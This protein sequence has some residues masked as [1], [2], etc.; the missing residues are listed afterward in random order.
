V[1]GVTWSAALIVGLLAGVRLFPITIAVPIA[2]ALVTPGFVVAVSMSA[3]VAR[4]RRAR[5]AEF[6]RLFAD[7]PRWALITAGVLFFAF[8][9]AAM[10]ALGGLAGNAENRNGRYV[11]NNHGSITVIDKATYDNALDREE[12]LMLGVLGGFGAGGAVLGGDS[13]LRIARGAPNQ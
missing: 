9:M 3:S 7:L 13:I 1:V 12:R 8:W 4:G 2:A 10:T 11:L 5:S 6:G